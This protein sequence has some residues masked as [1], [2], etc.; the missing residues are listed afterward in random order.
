ML[1]NA[2]GSENLSGKSFVKVVIIHP[3]ICGISSETSRAASMHYLISS[4]V[5]KLVNS[6]D[7]YIILST[8]AHRG[9]IVAIN[10]ACFHILMTSA[11]QIAGSLTVYASRY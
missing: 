9:V 6:R 2:T 7:T 3:Q 8:N 4:I 1:A 11:N 5:Y 10:P